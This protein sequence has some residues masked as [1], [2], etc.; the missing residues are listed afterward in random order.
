MKYVIGSVPFIAF[1]VLLIAIVLLLRVLFAGSLGMVKTKTKCATA[2]VRG[3]YKV[4]K[5]RSSGVYTIYFMRFE[6][7]KD[8]TIELPVPKKIFKKAPPGTEGTLY[9]KG[10]YFVDFVINE[11]NK[12]KPQNE[13]AAKEETYILNGEVVK[14]R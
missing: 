12:E 6:L 10:S 1:G 13:E 2:T 14:K 9:Y 4:D 3:K 11:E 7:S 5:M 8:D